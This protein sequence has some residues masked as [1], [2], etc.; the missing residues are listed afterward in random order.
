MP[1]GSSSRGVR[2]SYATSL[3]E[4]SIECN[5]MAIFGWKKSD[6]ARPYIEK[7]NKLKQARI[8]MEQGTIVQDFDEKIVQ[9]LKTYINQGLMSKLASP[10][11]LE[12]VFSA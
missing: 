1:K 5:L 12:P 3:A 11:G 8:A 2:K 7:A 4:H 9:D 6:E 10:T